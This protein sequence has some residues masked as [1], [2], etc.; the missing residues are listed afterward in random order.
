MTENEPENFPSEE[1]LD[2][3]PSMNDLL[4]MIAQDQIQAYERRQEAQKQTPPPAPPEE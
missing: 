4:A 2:S 3:L 1:E